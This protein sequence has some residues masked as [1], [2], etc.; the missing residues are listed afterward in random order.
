MVLNDFQSKFVA[1][2]ITE[3]KEELL[4]L[5]PKQWDQLDF[6]E[7]ELAYGG[8]HHLNDDEADLARK[9]LDAFQDKKDLDALFDRI[10]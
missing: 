8:N 6:L 10:V 2:V 1:L 4:N 7:E 3:T 5:T 9:C